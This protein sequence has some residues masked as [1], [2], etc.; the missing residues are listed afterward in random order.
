MDKMGER[1]ISF[2]V[3]GFI[4]IFCILFATLVIFSAKPRASMEN[5]QLTSTSQIHESLGSLQ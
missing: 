3:K 5:M 1:A 4:V 2:M